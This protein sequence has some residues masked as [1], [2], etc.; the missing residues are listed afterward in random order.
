MVIDDSGAAVDLYREAQLFPGPSTEG[1]LLTQ[2]GLRVNGPLFPNPAEGSA[3]LLVAVTSEGAPAIV[4]LLAGIV[5]ADGTHHAGGA[6]AEACKALMEDEENELPDVPLVPVR[7]IT[8]VLGAEHKST[9]GRAPGVYEALQM[10]RYVT[11]LAQMVPLPPMAVL[12]GGRRMAAAVEWIH[13]KNYT[14]MD[15]KADN[16]FV[17]SEGR[18]RLGDFGS[19]VP[20]DSPVTSTTTWFAPGR[21]LG[22]PA[23]PQYDWHMLAVALVCE[24]NRNN[25]KQLLVEGS[26]SP[27][28]KLIAAVEELHGREG[29]DELALFLNGLLQK[30][31]YP[32][33]VQ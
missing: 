25:W 4:K 16:I 19:A 22:C 17:D 20:I 15:I 6:E 23:K 21:L 14:H 24:V 5:S 1:H 29:C 30:A 26:Y 7:I 13:K 2:H 28:H 18:W 12:A 33:V 27:A 32:E 8:L 11:S 3:N 9:V 10:P 31:G